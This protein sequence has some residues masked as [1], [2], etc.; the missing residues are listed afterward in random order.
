MDAPAVTHRVVYRFPQNWTDLFGP[1][2]GPVVVR[3]KV[4]GY[5][6]DDATWSGRR[7]TVSVYR[8]KGAR[9]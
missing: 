9:R 8:L 5:H 7:P 1:G 2:S 3:V 6:A 4:C